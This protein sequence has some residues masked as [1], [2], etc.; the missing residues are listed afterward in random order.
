MSDAVK[1]NMDTPSS[2]AAH[3]VRAIEKDAKDY[4][5]GW[6]ESLFV[7][8]N[9]LFPRLVDHAVKKQNLVTRDFAREH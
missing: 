4:Y 6:P 5:I 1:M 7:R 2:V 3:I 9:A 8:I